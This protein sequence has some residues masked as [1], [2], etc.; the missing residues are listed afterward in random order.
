MYCENQ[1]EIEMTDFQGNK[2]ILTEKSGCCIVPTTY[3][4]RKII[5][6]CRFNIR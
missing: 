4:L 6:I 5:R 2:E 3:V 1:T